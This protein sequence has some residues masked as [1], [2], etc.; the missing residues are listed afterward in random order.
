MKE[1]GEISSLEAKIAIFLSLFI[2]DNY[3][4]QLADYSYSPLTAAH[5]C[6][7]LSVLG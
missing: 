2:R 6:G 5:G 4:S 3:P 1:A 7:V